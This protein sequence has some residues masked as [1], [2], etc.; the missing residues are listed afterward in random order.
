MYPASSKTAIAFQLSKVDLSPLGK[1][2]WPVKPPAHRTG[3]ESE[4]RV[5]FKTVKRGVGFKTPADMQAA[6]WVSL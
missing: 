5:P 6:I 2:L 3:R 4:R 1:G